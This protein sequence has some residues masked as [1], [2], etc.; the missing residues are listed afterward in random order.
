[1]AL[2]YH[3]IWYGMVRCSI[4]TIPYHNIPPHQEGET[5]EQL[6]TYFTLNDAQEPIG[7]SRPTSPHPQ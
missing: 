4:V 2:P 7:V 6:R 3:T 5:P 1:M